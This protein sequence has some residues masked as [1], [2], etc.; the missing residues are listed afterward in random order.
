MA[1]K[2]TRDWLSVARVV[3]QAGFAAFILI[4]AARHHTSAVETASTHAYCPFGVIASL[5][6]LVTTGKFAP[7]IHPS[8]LILGVGAIL[9]ALVAGAAFCGWVCP[10]GALEDALNWLRAKLRIRE[11]RV[12]K[13]ADRLLRYGRYVTLVGIIYA[14]AVTAKLWFADYD[15]YYTI[16]RLD[17]R[18]SLDR[19]ASWP[20]YGV[21]AAVV[22]CSLFIPRLW[23]RYLCPLGGLLNLVQRISPIKVRRHAPTCISCKR[24]DRVCPTRLEVSTAGAVKQ[25]CVMCLRCTSACPIPGALEIALPGYEK[26]RPAAPKGGA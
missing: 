11:L 8:S 19:A 17:W 12:P 24:C 3:S 6:P 25:N 16:F 18:F 20:A 14:T 26:A 10:L 9:S 7:K 21:S 5:W 13:L 1:R 2:K 15:P 4:A 22:G 23:C